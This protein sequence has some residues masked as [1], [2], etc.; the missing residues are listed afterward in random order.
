MHTQLVGM[1]SGMEIGMES[2]DDCLDL[3]SDKI[4]YQFVF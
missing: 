3:N 2:E 4:D 1:E